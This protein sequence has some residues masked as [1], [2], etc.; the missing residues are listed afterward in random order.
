MYV[1]HDSRDLFE[2][3]VSCTE[4]IKAVWL[5]SIGIKLTVY[6]QYSGERDW[7]IKHMVV[8]RFVVKLLGI[9]KTRSGPEFG[10]WHIKKI[11]KS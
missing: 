4:R 6:N 9:L 5:S 8:A 11:A 10:D 1:L 2:S 3:D 7:A